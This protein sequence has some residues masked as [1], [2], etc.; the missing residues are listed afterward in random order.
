[1]AIE[2][3]DVHSRL[4]QTRMQGWQQPTDRRDVV[5]AIKHAHEQGI[6][7]IASGGRHAMGGQQF[8]TDGILLD[9]RLLNAVIG[10][11]QEH[12]LLRIGAGATWPKVIAGIRERDPT[13]RWAIIQKQTGADDLTLG[14]SISA[15]GHGRVLGKGPIVEDV[16]AM[17]IVAADGE[18]YSCSRDT[19][20]EL[21]KLVIGGYGLFGVV[22]DVTLRLGPRRKVRRI[23][24]VI[25]IEDAIQAAQ[26]R[27]EEGCTYGDF[28]YAIHSDDED[29]LRRGVMAC[30]R[31]VDGDQPVAE[32]DSDL[33]DEDW[34]AL[35]QLAL[36]D[37]REA[38]QRYAEHYLRTHGNVYWSDTMQLATYIPDYV[39]MLAQAMGHSE[40]RE[41]L[42]ITELYVPPAAMP[43]FIQRAQAVLRETGVDTI[44]GTIRSI[45]Q[46]D[47][48]FLPWARQQYGCVIFNLRV[49]HTDRGIA[50][51]RQ[52]AQQLIDIAA[53]HGG[54]FF[55]TYHPWATREQI[56][57]CYPE[58]RDWLEKKRA[59]DPD[60][61]FQSDW[62][63]RLREL[64]ND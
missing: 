9:T 64:F 1:M 53:D 15:N 11:D 44:Y 18:I 22:T 55:L 32:G 51:T 61:I 2:V 62:Y 50:Q 37:K 56:E 47:T 12:G 29:Y 36:H 38:F 27:F 24:D 35:L 46:D 26:R 45:R 39:D 34:S 20:P 28:Q 59:H 19:Y 40:V 16:E 25:Q 43:R 10:F 49:E 58:I 41:S 17:T 57:R 31:P 8:C 14:G 42:M 48:T 6:P 60:G 7:I 54:S 52:A 13:N 23:V 30:Y 5:E 4:N 3:N 63:R 21:F 33:S